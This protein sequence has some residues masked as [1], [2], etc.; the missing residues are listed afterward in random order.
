MNR[1]GMV[2][3][4]LIAGV[5]VA[6]CSKE[7]AAES[8]E[9]GDPN[10]VLVEVNGD[11]LTSGALAADVARLEAA[12]GDRIPKD[13][14]DYARQMMR[15][16]LAQSFLMEGV[17]VKAAKDAGHVVTDEERLARQADI[18]K[19]A[20][21]QP[22]A[23]KTFD[24]FLEKFPLGKDRAL[25]E[26]ENG[27]L[28]DKL[29]KGENAKLDVSGLAAEAQKTIDG[30]VSNNA[31]AASADAEAL[32]KVQELKTQLDKADDVPAKFAELAKAN[33]K[34]PSSAKGG[35]LGEFT[36]GQ[37]VKEFDE[38]AFSM[39]VGKVSDP[40][41]T[42]FGYHLILVTKKTPATEAA[43][44][45]PASPEKVQASHILVN[46]GKTRPVPK[47]EDV[48]AQLKK[49]AERENVQKF[50]TSLIRAADVKVVDEFKGLLPPP[51][52]PA[53]A[54]AKQAVET[55]AEK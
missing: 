11:R 52:T 46:A 51:E 29:L 14:L 42:Q 49:R 17:L 9:V 40:V 44:D 48:V 34:C 30:I 16:Q 21:K 26:F 13:Q 55:P 22:G 54:D 19:S 18:M 39:P 24:E 3:A 10:E 25:K 27:I 28:I 35:D 1:I 23:P 38:A 50:I 8:A 37:M 31:A 41:K 32:K 7:E 4:A 36:H 43:G 5:M 12:Q 45:T 20:A 2:G 47:V 53:G 33:S 15:N 6:G